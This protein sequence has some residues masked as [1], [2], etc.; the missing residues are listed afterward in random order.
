MISIIGTS[1]LNTSH[2]RLPSLQGIEPDLA[3][4]LQVVLTIIANKTAKLLIGDN[5]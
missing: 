4:A 1:T 2:P 5:V 3:K